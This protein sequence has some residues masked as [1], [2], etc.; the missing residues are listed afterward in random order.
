[1]EKIVK[2]G[3]DRWGAVLRSNLGCENLHQESIEFFDRSEDMDKGL[4]VIAERGK[5]LVGD[6]RMVGNPSG[7]R[8][9][10]KIRF[11]CECFSHEDTI[12]VLNIVQHKGATFMFW[13]K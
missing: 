10:L 7:R 8:Q 5:Q 11:S 13:D 3:T 4:H 1:M 6:D 2:F 9:G 12:Q